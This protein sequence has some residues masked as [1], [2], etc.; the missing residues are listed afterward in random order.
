V[1]LDANLEKCDNL[2]A[3]SYIEYFVVVVV[4]VVD[5]LDSGV[6][7]DTGKGEFKND[8][9]TTSSESTTLGNEQSI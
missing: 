5:S 7:S 8:Y 3:T 2:S 9:R 6:K 1:R 4:V